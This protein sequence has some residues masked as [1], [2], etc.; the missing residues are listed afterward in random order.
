VCLLIPY[1]QI[2]TP[3]SLIVAWCNIH[4]TFEVT[5]LWACG[6]HL[7]HWT[8][9]QHFNVRWS[10]ILIRKLSVWIWL[11]IQTLMTWLFFLRSQMKQI[12]IW[13]WRFYQDLLL[14]LINHFEEKFFESQL[15]F[16]IKLNISSK[17]ILIWIDIQY[18]KGAS[19]QLRFK[20]FIKALTLV[21]YEIFNIIEN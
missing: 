17:T 20:A 3:H 9:R 19:S 18:S 5:K 1:N 13:F 7:S 10:I 2:T 15:R 21:S 14:M 16:T 4:S 6:K 11:E 8:T 12:R